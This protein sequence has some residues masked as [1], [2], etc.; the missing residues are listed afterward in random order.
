[1]GTAA[2]QTLVDL[3]APGGSGPCLL[4][5]T[6]ALP[7]HPWGSGGMDTNNLHLTLGLL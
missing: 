5:V 2:S 3:S 6:G 7:G 4:A 1:M